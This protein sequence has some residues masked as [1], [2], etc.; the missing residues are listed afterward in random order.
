MSDQA[1]SER[2]LGRE[3]VVGFGLVGSAALLFADVLVRAGSLEYTHGDIDG[4][5]HTAAFLAVLAL[6]AAGLL[7]VWLARSRHVLARWLLR[8]AAAGSVVASLNAVLQSQPLVGLGLFFF[9]GMPLLLA[10]WAEGW[11]EEEP[12]A[13]A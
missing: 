5:L 9:S 4:P 8:A 12:S 10:A 11:A 3:A 13:S 6:A 2:R 1:T 7:G